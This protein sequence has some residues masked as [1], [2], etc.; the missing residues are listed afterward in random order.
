MSEVFRCSVLAIPAI[1]GGILRRSRKDI[2]SPSVYLEVSK[3]KYQ[4]SL[5]YDA[6]IANELANSRLKSRECAS[7][8]SMLSSPLFCKTENRPCLILFAISQ[9]ALRIPYR[10]RCT[11]LP[12]LSLRPVSASHEAGLPGS[13][14]QKRL[15]DGPVRWL[16]HLR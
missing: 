11:R 5:F 4:H 3:G 16:R 13:C 8:F 14:I 15:P 2:G 6:H 10:R 9:P 7:Q 1:L 12:G